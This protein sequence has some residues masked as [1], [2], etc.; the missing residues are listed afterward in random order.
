MYRKRDREQQYLEGFRLP[1]GGKLRADN[2]WVKLAGMMPWDYIEEVYARNMDENRGVKAIAARVAFGALFIKEHENL[3]DRKTVEYIA[4]NPYMQY[5][6]GLLEFREEELFDASMM[7]HL[8]KRFPAEAIGEINR[9]MF[10][11]EKKDE[12]SGDP[13]GDP[14][15]KGE[16]VLDATCAPADIRYPNDLSLLDEAR[17]N[18]EEMIDELWPHSGRKGRKTRYSRRKARSQYLSIAKQKRPKSS[19]VN[20]AIDKQLGCVKSNIDA[21]GEL[22]ME[23]GLDKLEEKRFQRLMTICELYRQQ[24]EMRGNRSHKCENRICSLRQP[25]VRPIVRGKAGRRF[26]FGQKL[27]FAVVGGYTFI[28]NQSFDNFHEGVTLIESAGRYR[29]TYGAYPEAILAD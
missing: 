22:L 24:S 2:Q 14:P 5:F 29:R 21:I 3:T 23:T 1:F 17:R 26:E 8:R 27:G 9:R 13:G 15:N 7:V 28:E 16:L 25:H 18:T 6:L 11:P 12:D 4:E 10:E 20:K 19:R